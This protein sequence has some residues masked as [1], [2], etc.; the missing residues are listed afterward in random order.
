MIHQVAKAYALEA[1]ISLVD[2]PVELAIEEITNPP[3]YDFDNGDELVVIQFSYK[4]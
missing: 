4:D 2:S 1:T 3:L